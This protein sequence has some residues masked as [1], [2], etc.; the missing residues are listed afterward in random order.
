SSPPPPGPPPHQATYSGCRAPQPRRAPLPGTTSAPATRRWP[1][2]GTA[3]PGPFNSPP[4]PERH[5][6]SPP[7]PAGQPTHSEGDGAVPARKPGH[8]SGNDKRGADQRGDLQ[9]RPQV[10]G[11]LRQKRDAQRAERRSE[12]QEGV[13]RAQPGPSHTIGSGDLDKIALMSPVRISCCAADDAAQ[14][15]QSL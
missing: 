5:Q 8:A 13:L 3:R 10:I 15:A 7:R 12:P 9:L 6:G 14:S 1:S 2:A 11:T 4:T